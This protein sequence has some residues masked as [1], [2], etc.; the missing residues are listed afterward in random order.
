MIN[1][2]DML[3]RHC[4]NKLVS[5]IHQVV[6]PPRKEWSKPR[7]SIPFFMHPVSDMKLDCLEQCI[8]EKHPKLYDDISAGEFLAQRLRVQELFRKIKHQ[9]SNE[10]KKKRLTQCETASFLK[11]CYLIKFFVQQELPAKLC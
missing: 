8:D 5:T 1:V 9:A 10:L 4:N 3:S 6:N 7:F 11:L 2:G